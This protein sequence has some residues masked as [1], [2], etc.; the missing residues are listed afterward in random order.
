MITY[1]ADF[2]RYSRGGRD[3][4]V[5]TITAAS[6]VTLMLLLIFVVIGPA[7]WT[8]NLLNLCTGGLSLSNMVERAGSGA[9]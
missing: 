2:C 6:K 1:A 4:W 9:R 8:I 5:G 7:Q 3:I